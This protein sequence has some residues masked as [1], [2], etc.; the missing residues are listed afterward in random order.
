METRGEKGEGRRWEGGEK[1]RR[2]IGKAKSEGQGV[3]ESR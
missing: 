2:R 3:S 1:D